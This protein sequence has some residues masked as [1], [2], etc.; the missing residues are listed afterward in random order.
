VKLEQLVHK[1]KEVSLVNLEKLVFQGNKV[2]LDQR[3]MQENVVNVE[4]SVLSVHQVNL[5]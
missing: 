2:V 5:V 1:V 4:L 3:V